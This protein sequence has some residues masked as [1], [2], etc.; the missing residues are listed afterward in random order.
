MLSYPHSLQIL[1][2][3]PDEPGLQICPLVFH[4]FSWFLYSS[5]NFYYKKIK[6][7]ELVNS[8]CWLK[9]LKKM[10][11]QSYLGHQEEKLQ[12]LWSP[13]GFCRIQ[14]LTV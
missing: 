6:N 5:L 10:S 2:C 4:L 12:A 3:F 1:S 14:W 8:K 13:N 11:L 7:S 9:L